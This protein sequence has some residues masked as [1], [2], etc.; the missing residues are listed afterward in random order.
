[1]SLSASGAP[2]GNPVPVTH[3]S[4]LLAFAN[5]ALLILREVP[6]RAGL[7]T[8][9][10]SGVSLMHW[11]STLSGVGGASVGGDITQSEWSDDLALQDLLDL[12]REALLGVDLLT[13]D[14]VSLTLIVSA[15]VAEWSVELVRVADRRVDL[16]VL[17]GVSIVLLVSTVV[18]SVLSGT[19]DGAGD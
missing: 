7:G 12:R 1:M 16:L 18:I 19:D 14:G 5:V 3:S 15:V 2:K 8:T 17:A 6:L 4:Q 11:A 10:V 13:P 9:P